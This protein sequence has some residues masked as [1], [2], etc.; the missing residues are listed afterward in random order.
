MARDRDRLADH[1]GWGDGRRG[2]GVLSPLS[3]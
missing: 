1:P 2:G 3:T